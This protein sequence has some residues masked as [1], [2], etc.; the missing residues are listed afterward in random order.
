MRP[1]VSIPLPVVPDRYFEWVS[2]KLDRDAILHYLGSPEYIYRWQER[3]AYVA[4][5]T[6]NEANCPIFDLRALFLDQ[7]DFRD[8]MSRD[9]IHPNEAGYAVIREAAFKRWH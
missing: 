4:L 9:G 3:Y 6:A 2:Q 5:K 8:M 1:V 7:R